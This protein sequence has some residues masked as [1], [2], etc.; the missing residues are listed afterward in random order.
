MPSELASL[1]TPSLLL[2]RDVLTANLE[3]MAA[4]AAALGVRLRPHLKTAKSAD[5]AALATRGPVDG[6]TVSTLKEA[7]YFFDHGHRD[8]F[9]AMTIE[10]G[11]F[12]R[13]AALLRRGAALTVACDNPDAARALA[14]AGRELGVRFPVLIEIDCGEH[15]SGLAPDDPAVAEIGAILHAGPGTELRG[16]CTHSGHSYAG[17][18]AA[19]HRAVAEEER[20][21]VVR[22]AGVLRARGLPCPVVSVGS[23]PTA[24]HA[25][26]LDGVT[27]VRAGVYMLGDLFQAGIG[28]CR[29]EDIAVS[30]LT[31]VIGHRPERNTLLVDAG[32]LALSKD[33]STAKLPPAQNAGYGLV[34]MTDGEL[35]P[36]LTVASVYQEHGL[37]TGPTPIDFARFPIGS[38]L[39]ILPNHC[40]ITAAAYDRYHVLAGGAVGAE[41]PRI[42]GW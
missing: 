9:Y 17:R 19:E 4:R 22:A 38:R 32:A 36:G 18:T 1:S 23:T 25:A 11:K 34:A 14:R 39:R 24:L 12:A 42:N 10:P 30:V 13:A 29:I 20:T 8:L 28:S 35:L 15:R 5:V 2:D 27:E 37:I 40:C 21:A 33:I 7:E 16:L 31:A 41:W 6:F 26:H 3:R